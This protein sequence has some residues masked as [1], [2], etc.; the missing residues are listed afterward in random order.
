MFFKKLK[1][2]PLYYWE[3]QSIVMA[4]P[5]QSECENLLK[6]VFERINKSKE[7][8]VIDSSTDY[9]NQT[10]NFKVKYKKKTYEVGMYVGGVNVPEYYL[11]NLAINDE[12]KKALLEAKTAISIF[13]KFDE[14][15]KTSFHLQIKIANLVV[16]NMLALLDESAERLFVSEWVKLTAESEFTPSSRDLYAVQ[17]INDNDGSVWLHTHGLL[18]CHI[19]ELEILGSNSDVS[20]NHYNLINSYAMY[21]ID[22]KGE[23]VGGDY[24][25][26][27]INGMPVVATSISWV[28]ALKYYKN[29][30]NGGKRDR[31]NGHNSKS[32]VIFLYTSEEN[33]KNNVYSK[34]SEFNDLWGDNPLFFISDAETSRMKNVAIERFD[35][36]KKAY[37]DKKNTILLKIGLPLEEKGK[38]EHIWFELLEIKKDKFKAKLTQEPYYFEN[39]HEGDEEWY[40]LS[41]LTDWIIYTETYS[42]A[43]DTAYLL[44]K[45]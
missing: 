18:R 32:N 14:D 42:I 24:I 31:K 44:N 22:K 21:L 8:K 29:V 25:G 35:Y 9:S 37:K 15:P 33:E 40:T 28:D 36:V 38:Y 41:D 30:K 16:P 6:N 1:E 17:A 13:M 5:E 43:P 34:V 23:S 2:V 10:F 19:N 3:E 27:L 45:F 20:R 4:I 26:R 11:N 39:M 12:K 7:I